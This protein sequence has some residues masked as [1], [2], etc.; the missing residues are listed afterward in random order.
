LQLARHLGQIPETIRVALVN[1]YEL[2]LEGLRILL[3][4]YEPEI[5]VVELD[6]N[7][8]TAARR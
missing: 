4:P 3:R 2:V 8:K 1:D 5:C 7:G 6:V